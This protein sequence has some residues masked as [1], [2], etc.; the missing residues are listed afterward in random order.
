MVKKTIIVTASKYINELSTKFEVKE[1][2]LFGSY[3]S[4]LA[5]VDS[6]IDIA[7]VLGGNISDFFNIQ[8]DLMRLRR[9][10]DLRIEPHPISELDFNN[11][12]NPFVSE[13]KNYGIKLI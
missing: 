8:M 5:K 6:D 11:I 1:A 12:N 7:V 3:A 2:Y 4:G 10:I 13:I 9:K